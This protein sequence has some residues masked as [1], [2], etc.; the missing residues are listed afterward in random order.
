LPGEVTEYR[1]LPTSSA[2]K[3]VAGSNTIHLVGY[4]YSARTHW[5]NTTFSRAICNGCAVSCFDPATKTR[6]TAVKQDGNW[7]R[8]LV[9]EP[10]QGFWLHCKGMTNWS[11][12]LPLLLSAKQPSDR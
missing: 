12:T 6:V 11:A 9:F 2:A 3:A 8:D 1:S 4:A 7:S 10:G 5:T